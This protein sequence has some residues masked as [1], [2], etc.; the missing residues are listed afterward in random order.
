MPKLREEHFAAQNK[1]LLF[2][3]VAD[4]ESYPQFLPATLDAK[5]LSQEGEHLT[6]SLTI[7]YGPLQETFISDVFLDRANGT[8]RASLKEGRLKS[9][10]CLWQFTES[11]GG[12]NILC[13][14]DFDFYFGL[15][16]TIATPL[17][18]KAAKRLTQAFIARAQ[19]Q[20][21]K[22]Q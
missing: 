10:E 9:L 4:I 16:R 13:V 21:T 2:D 11:E 22:P 12:T 3:L 15:L 19:S 14:L 5:I 18:G 17:L 8:I 1:N 6:A 20:L 7:G